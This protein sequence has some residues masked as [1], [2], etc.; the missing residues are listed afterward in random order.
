MAE[1]ALRHVNKDNLR[2]VI[3][4]EVAPD[5]AHLVAPNVKS[6]AEA[7]VSEDA[8][9]RA[10]YAGEEPV[11]FL[12]LSERRAEPRYYLWRFM[13]DA[14]HQGKGYG[15]AA[16]A[17]LIDYVRDLPGA[18][19]LFV[20]WVPGDGSPAPFYRALGFVETGRVHDGEHEAVLTLS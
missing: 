20:S 5:Q 8:M 19:E 15:T 17:L 6:L 2:R 4:L 18:D 12:M 11:G 10:I 1:V 16:M 13:I 14:A 3:A 9:F 7:A